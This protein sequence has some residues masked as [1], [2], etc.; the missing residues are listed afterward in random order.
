MTDH[1]KQNS[2]CVN[3]GGPRAS[4]LTMVEK[5]VARAR[6]VHDVAESVRNINTPFGQDKA[7]E[8]TR[9]MDARLSNELQ[10]AVKVAQDPRCGLCIIAADPCA[11]HACWAVAI[12][13]SQIADPA[14]LRAALEARALHRAA[15]GDPTTG[16]TETDQRP[17]PNTIAHE[18]HLGERHYILKFDARED[19]SRF[20]IL[21]ESRTEPL[22]VIAKG[23]IDNELTNYDESHAVMLERVHPLDLDTLEG[24]LREQWQLTRIRL[25]RRPRKVT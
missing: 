16:E 18:V 3:C 4:L 22:F 9:T 11:C 23:L 7:D 8:L 10:S 25:R 5:S 1:P 20:V 6:V 17:T 2:V 24:V 19:A 14:S 13:E 15:A 12:D 21:G